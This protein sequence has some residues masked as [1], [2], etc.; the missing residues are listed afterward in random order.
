MTNL[1]LILSLR[2]DLEVAWAGKTLCEEL[3]AEM[4]V[5]NSTSAV[6]TLVTC[7]EICLVVVADEDKDKLVEMICKL[8]FNSNFVKPF[9]VLKKKSTSQ[10]IMPA[11]CVVEAVQSQE[12]KRSPAQS[13]MD[14]DKS[15]VCSRL[16][17]ATCR[18]QQ[19]AIC[20]TVLEVCQKNL[21]ST[22]VEKAS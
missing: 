7:L 15:S 16:S 13:V 1:V 17:L 6:W 21:V 11:M 22:V 4:V 12:V 19:L 8:R 2:A 5:L 18:R 9:L 20:V 14:E 3:V 10:K